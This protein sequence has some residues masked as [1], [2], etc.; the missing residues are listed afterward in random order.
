MGEWKYIGKERVD[1]KADGKGRKAD[2]TC[3]FYES[4]L[5]RFYKIRF[6]KGFHNY[7]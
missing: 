1:Y 3:R 4:V 2:R 7:L 5:R 6:Q